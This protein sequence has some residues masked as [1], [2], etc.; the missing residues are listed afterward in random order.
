M[1]EGL[2]EDKGKVMNCPSCPHLRGPVHPI[3]PTPCRVLLLGECPSYMEDRE[4]IPFIGPT[5]EEFTTVYIP[6]TGLTRSDFHIANVRL[7]SWSDYHNPTDQDAMDCANTFLAPLLNRVRPEIIVPMGAVACSIFEGIDLNMHH[8]I[9]QRGKW[10]SWSGWIF[11]TF[12]PTIGM[13]STSYMIPLMADFKRLGEILRRDRV[14]DRVDPWAGKEDYQVV[15]SA[16]DLVDYTDHYY[17]SAIE[18]NE[19]PIGEDTESLPDGSPYC[20]TF[21]LSPGTGRLIYAAD[22]HLIADYA[23]L[24]RDLDPFHLFHN[25]LHDV[26]SFNQWSIPINRFRDTMVMAYHLC[27]GGGGD[28]EDTES[29]AGRGSL[30]LK[31]L[32]YR[33]LA[34][35]MTSF[36]DTVYPHSM[37][38]ALDWLTRGRSLVAPGT[39]QDYPNCASCLHPPSDHG[40][41]TGRGRCACGG[42]PRFK[43]AEKP[44]TSPE[45]K[46]ISLL[47]RKLNNLIMKIEGGAHYKDADPWKRVGTEWHDHD[48]DMLLSVLPPMP[49]PSIA[50]VPEPDLLRYA[51]RDPDATLRL[52]YF[53]LDC[54]PW[55]YYEE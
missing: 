25:Y 18:G 28:E 15:R 37:P 51:V 38:Y 21:S 34:M 53:L 22:T 40:G 13:R 4:H 32:S 33:H 47:H 31:V 46:L 3:G 5:G 30:S 36:K 20:L 29:K 35:S 11:P 43:K 49:Q 41:K 12:H 16:N 42:C 6:L 23:S 7:C 8:G 2:G 54:Q 27:L 52:Y 26:V 39:P 10:G 19:V 1:G 14:E 17:V 44:K 9:P 55:I 45:D 24:I 48:R 50:H